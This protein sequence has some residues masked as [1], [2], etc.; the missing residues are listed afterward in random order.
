MNQR[1][2]IELQKELEKERQIENLKQQMMSPYYLSQQNRGYQLQTRIESIERTDDNTYVNVVLDHPDAINVPGRGGVNGP[3]FFIANGE[4]VASDYGVTKTE[5]I[6]SNCSDYYCSVVRF[7][8]PLDQVPLLICPIVPNQPN[9]LLTPLI[10]GI[11]AGVTTNPLSFFAENLIY[12]PHND[13]EFVVQDQP[14]QVITP[15]HYIYSYQTLVDMFNSAL[16]SLYVK[17]GF[18]ALFPGYLAPYFQFDPVTDLFSLIV[19]SFFTDVTPPATFAPV[20]FINSAS[21]TFLFSFD[22]LQNITN[23]KASNV[24]PFGNDYYF[25]QESSV[26]TQYYPP[27]VAIPAPTTPPILPA[28]SL[29]YKFTQE[30]SIVEYWSSLRK[31][32]IVTNSIPVK[33]EYVPASGNNGISDSSGV[34][35]SY[36]ILTDFVPNISSTA[37]D[38]RSIAYYVPSSQYRLVDMISTNPLQKIDI[39]LFWEDRDGNLYPLLISLYQQASM[40]IAFLRKSLYNNGSNLLTKV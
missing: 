22:L 27:G 6:L 4:P 28:T 29:Y 11:L 36:P 5:P 39:R 20:I 16:K 1:D 26:T 38:S 19:P 35:V 24:N 30:F 40:K 13:Y 9:P 8:I 37:G 32:L 15:F 21:A 34:N 3:T 17:T 12:Q 7:T 33:N 10:I 2:F 23:P 14:T 25:I 31:I 18:A